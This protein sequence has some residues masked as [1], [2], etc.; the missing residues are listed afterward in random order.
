MFDASA[1]EV[2]SL[3]RVAVMQR[4]VELQELRDTNLAIRIANA[5]N[6]G[7]TV[8]GRSGGISTR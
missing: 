2:R 6:G 1:G 3:V 7:R 4:A 8:N 5:Q